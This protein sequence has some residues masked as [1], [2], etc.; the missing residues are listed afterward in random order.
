MILPHAWRGLPAPARQLAALDERCEIA[1]A[2]DKHAFDE[3]DRHRDSRSSRE[4]R[5]GSA[6]RLECCAACRHSR[7]QLAIPMNRATAHPLLVPAIAA[8][9]F[10]PPFMISGVAVALPALGTDLAAGATALSL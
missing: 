5:D 1:R 3:H 2:A 6:L 4:R 9:Q 10:A 8:S 7:A